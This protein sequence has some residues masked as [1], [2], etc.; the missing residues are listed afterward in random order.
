MKQMHYSTAEAFSWQSLWHIVTGVPLPYSHDL[1]CSFL[2][3][4]LGMKVWMLNGAEPL[5]NVLDM[6]TL[7]A[8]EGFG[9]IVLYVSYTIKHCQLGPTKH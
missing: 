2:N 7:H 1:A 5:C 9:I 3:V 8:Q 6:S 4:V